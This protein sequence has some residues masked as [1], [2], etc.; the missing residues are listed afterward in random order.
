MNRLMATNRIQA[1]A[2]FLTASSAGVGSPVSR[3]KDQLRSK[4]WRS[5]I[6]WTIIAGFN[7]KIDFNRSGVKVATI[8]AGTYATGALL[9]TAITAALEAADAT[10]AWLCSYSAGIF[11]F[12]AVGFPFTLLWASGANT[13]TACHKDIGF[14]VADT[15]SSTT[16]TGASAVYQSRHWVKADLVVAAEV[17]AS[18]VVNH[19]LTTDG[20]I[21][22]QGNATDTWTAPTVDRVMP[23]NT[24]LRIDFPPTNTLQ[25]WRL[26]IFDCANPLGYSEIGVWF[27]GPYTAPAKDFGP[28]WEKRPQS[29]NQVT[30]AISGAHFTD[31]K[32]ERPVWAAIAWPGVTLAERDILMAFFATAPVGIPFFFAFDAVASPLLTE[33]VMLGEAAGYSHVE[34]PDVFLLSI[35]TLVGVLG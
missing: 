1:P 21:S 5:A 6:G 19:N 15:G 7:D 31:Q 3:L 22:L 23:G 24:T 33:Y 2:T 9:A 32:T 14:A 11:D 10:P 35:P 18:I 25:W 12:L 8:A 28:N 29:Q 27:L 13:L 4:S 16:H 30:F 34:G 17:L 20:V 26:L